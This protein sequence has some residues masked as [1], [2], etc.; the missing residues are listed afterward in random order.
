MLYQKKKIVPFWMSFV[1]KIKNKVYFQSVEVF[2]IWSRCYLIGNFAFFFF[3]STPSVWYDVILQVEE[4][5][6][7]VYWV[8]ST[9]WRGFSFGCCFPGIGIGAP[10]LTNSLVGFGYGFGM[11]VGLNPYGGRLIGNGRCIGCHHSFGWRWNSRLA[12]PNSHSNTNANV[13]NK[14]V[15]SLFIVAARLFTLQNKELN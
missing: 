9:N 13:A 1:F 15:N 11:L 10:G 5:S 14:I 4:N 6:C 3:E 8:L 12:C 2:F 7:T